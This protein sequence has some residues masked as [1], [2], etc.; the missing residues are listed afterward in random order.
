MSV[1]KDRIVFKTAFSAPEVEKPTTELKGLKLILSGVDFDVSLDYDLTK[2]NW[3]QLDL[4]TRIRLTTEDLQEK[5]PDCII[6][7]SVQKQNK[8]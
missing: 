6:T 4:R 2:R 1:G 5:L 7:A 8:C 3:D